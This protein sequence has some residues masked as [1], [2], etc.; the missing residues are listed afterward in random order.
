MNPQIE[1]AHWV[2]NRRKITDEQYT[3]PV[4]TLPKINDKKCFPKAKQI[5]EKVGFL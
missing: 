2:L 4:V 1:I 5:R 3:D